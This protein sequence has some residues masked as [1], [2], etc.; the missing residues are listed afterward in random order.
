M[1][2]S[3]NPDPR[4]TGTW[5]ET[6]TA[7]TS[8]MSP[9]RSSHIVNFAMAWSHYWYSSWDCMC[10]LLGSCHIL[11][12][13]SFRLVPSSLP[14]RPAPYSYSCVPVVGTSLQE[15]GCLEKFE[16]MLCEYGNL[17]PI[18]YFQGLFPGFQI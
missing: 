5:P 16:R 14:P 15:Y 3:F 9:D 13:H 12:L 8:D 6:L 18:Y 10:A 11:W 1:R 17:F 7:I 2:I 4:T